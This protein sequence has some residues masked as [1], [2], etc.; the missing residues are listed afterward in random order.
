[1]TGARTVVADRWRSRRLNSPNDVVVAP[2]GAVWFTDPSYGHLQGFRPPPEVGDHVY[3]WEPVS[4][5][6]DVAADGFDKPNGI[7][8][9]ADGRTL[10][11]T[12][13]GANQTPGSFHV[14]R[15]HHVEAFDV[16][17]GDRLSG[18]R[19]LAVTAPGIP[20]GLKTD[21]HGRVFVSSDTGVLVLSPDGRLLGEIAVSGTVNF[22]FGGIDGRVLFITT[23][24]AVV[25]AVF[26]NC[27]AN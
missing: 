14:D 2:D 27:P 23:D 16:V 11:V 24:T 5:A 13:S 22:T 26:T 10:Y 7:A 17:G 4:G 21:R 25:A 19:L 1:M 15:P 8:L 12:D 6:V 3:R 18:R 9:T 20:D